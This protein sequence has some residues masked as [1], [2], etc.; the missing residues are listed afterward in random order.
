[1]VTKKSAKKEKY[2]GIYIAL[3]GIDYEKDDIQYHFNAGETLM[4]QVY[5]MIL[6]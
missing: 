1:M 3:T 6:I 5:L 2:T 4:L